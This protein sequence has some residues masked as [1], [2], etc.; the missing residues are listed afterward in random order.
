LVDMHKYEVSD[1]FVEIRALKNQCKFNNCLHVNEPQCAV[2]KAVESGN[3]QPSR[4]Q[5]YL[6]IMNGEELVE[7]WESSSVID[8]EGKRKR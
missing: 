4:Y 7:Q 6:S 8:K 1:Y 3:I 2:I 5:S